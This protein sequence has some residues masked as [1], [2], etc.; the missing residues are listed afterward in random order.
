MGSI[1][2]DFERKLAKRQYIS[3][4]F[5]DKVQ[6]RAP[7]QVPKQFN[8]DEYNSRILEV[9]H[10]KLKDYFCHLL[11]DIDSS[12]ELNSE[13]IR[14]ILAD[15]NRSLVIAGTDT[16]KINIIIA[17]IKYLVEKKNVAP[18]DILVIG[19]PERTIE[20]MQEDINEMLNIPVSV[21]SF[22]SLGYKYIKQTMRYKDCRV[23]NEKERDEI[24]LNYLKRHILANPDTVDDF[25]D[26]FNV[27][28]TGRRGLIDDYYLKN[29]GDFRNFDDYFE[30]LIKY[31]LKE[32]NNFDSLLKRSIATSINAD[33]PRT[34]MGERVRSKGEAMIANWLFRHSISYTYRQA[35]DELLPDANDYRPNFTLYIGGQKFYIEYYEQNNDYRIGSHDK[36][37]ET[38]ESFHRKNHTNFIP[39]HYEPNNS[40]L[41]TLRTKLE[42]FGVR[43]PHE[44]NAKS[45]YEAI[46]RHNPLVEF[47][48]LETLFYETIDV[49][50]TSSC[51]DCFDKTIKSHLG[52]I[53]SLNERIIAEKQYKYIRDFYLFYNAAIHR[54][55]DE[56]SFDIAD[57]IY[58]AKFLVSRTENSIF[59]YKYI[60]IDEY[61]DISSGCFDLMRKLVERNKIKLIVVGNDWQTIHSFTKARI[62]QI[63]G[64]RDC[65]K[66]AKTFKIASAHDS[67]PSPAN[68]AGDF[69]MEKLNQIRKERKCTLGYF[70][71]PFVFLN[72]NG[73]SKSMEDEFSQAKQAILNIHRQRPSDR[74]LVLA[75]T[76]TILKT[77]MKS[78]A[79]F[80][81]GSDTKV[82]LT[83]LPSYKF[84][85]ATTKRSKDIKADWVIIVGQNLYPPSKTRSTFWLLRL[86]VDTP[87]E[88][89]ASFVEDRKIFYT[90]LTK[91][92]FK[93]ILL[94]NINAE[95]RDT[96]LN[97]IY[98]AM[99]D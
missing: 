70:N 12:I 38:K 77:M 90:A 99:R 61:Q 73:D 36:I 31:R 93:V 2:L 3:A 63:Y 86:F 47:R 4:S 68:V 98:H 11:D 76:N 95:K 30:S 21:T 96:F 15:E 75:R 72:F 37:R 67:Q 7:E 65:L 48:K 25:I 69:I 10:A 24:F 16:E 28:T 43:L 92:R 35:F 29:R 71:D 33:I 84:D 97:Y 55:A 59:H 50:K 17:K 91:A 78:K 52:D 20:K 1:L 40:Y 66:N 27:N 46:L 14:A 83:E 34:L 85:A 56:P 5:F 8:L 49:I 80:K 74:I 13:Q 58:Y 89:V 53:K 44:R 54:G 42:E 23:I 41:K 62:E 18:E 26:C 82:S 88:E 9:E 39:L 51:R 79:G 81:E 19:G 22:Y 45:I 94:R 6:K 57:V 32:V 64:F 87:K 60:L